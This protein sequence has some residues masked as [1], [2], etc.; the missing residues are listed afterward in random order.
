MPKGV[1]YCLGIKAKTWEGMTK[2][3]SNT[4]VGKKTGVQTGKMVP[5][6]TVHGKQVNDEVMVYEERNSWTH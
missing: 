3:P 2:M 6:K 5:G 1:S 4:R